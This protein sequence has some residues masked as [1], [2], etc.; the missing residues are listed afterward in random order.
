[1]SPLFPVLLVAVVMGTA[2]HQDAEKSPA[3]T[4]DGPEEKHLV[5]NVRGYLVLKQRGMTGWGIRAVSLPD[6]KERTVLPV[7]ESMQVYSLSGPDRDGRIGFIQRQLRPNRFSLRT[8]RLDGKEEKIFSRPGD[9]IWDNVIGESLAL[10]PQGG[11]VAFVRD[12][13]DRPQSHPRRHSR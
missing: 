6:L 12:P 10:A 13:K 3:Y 5:K 7:R 1:M 2:L 8:I 4:V 11:R 9:P